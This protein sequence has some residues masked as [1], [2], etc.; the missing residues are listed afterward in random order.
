MADEDGSKLEAS[1]SFRLGTARA[2]IR[3]LL[4]QPEAMQGWTRRRAREFLE[5]ERARDEQDDS[6]FLKRARAVLNEVA[7][8]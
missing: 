5:I 2:I 4:E 3:N 6:S 1:L 7:R 8:G